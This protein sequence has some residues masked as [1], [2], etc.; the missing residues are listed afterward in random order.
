[1]LTVL[2]L[3]LTFATLAA[4]ADRPAFNHRETAMDQANKRVETAQDLSSQQVRL[5]VLG[6][7][8]PRKLDELELLLCAGGQDIPCW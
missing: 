1:V 5:E 7:G 4:R 3:Q 6:E 2:P 8:E